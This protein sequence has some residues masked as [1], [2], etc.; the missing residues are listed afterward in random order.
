[1]LQRS[2][3]AVGDVTP[4]ASRLAWVTCTADC[5]FVIQTRQV[6]PWRH[7][8]VRKAVTMCCSPCLRTACSHTA[9]VLRSQPGLGASRLG[10]LGRIADMLWH[11]RPCAMLPVLCGVILMTSACRVAAVP[12]VRLPLHASCRHGRTCGWSCWKMCTTCW[13]RK[14]TTCCKLRPSLEAA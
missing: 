2:R 7:R 8:H 3:V 1:M 13:P 12:T 5:L 14:N 9:H 11:G 10:A 4:P 6:L